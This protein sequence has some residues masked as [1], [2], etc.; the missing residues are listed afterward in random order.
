MTFF[1]TVTRN[2]VDKIKS[3]YENT[4]TM[5]KSNASELPTI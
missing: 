1:P 4:T 2:N 3:N 5:E